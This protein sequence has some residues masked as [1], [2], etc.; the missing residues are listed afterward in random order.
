[1]E[2]IQAGSFLGSFLQFCGGV[3]PNLLHVKGGIR[4]LQG[5][6]GTLAVV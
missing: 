5:L 4:L 2:E 3:T 1:M 6:S